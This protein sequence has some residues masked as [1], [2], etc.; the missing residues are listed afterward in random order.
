MSK[1]KKHES[2][3]LGYLKSLSFFSDLRT[4]EIFHFCFANLEQLGGHISP[5][6]SHSYFAGLKTWRF[7]DSGLDQYSKVTHSANSK[8]AHVK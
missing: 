7:L 5:K 1:K 6:P 4:V 2:G 3:R 8:W